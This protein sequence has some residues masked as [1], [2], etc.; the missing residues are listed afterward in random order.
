MLVKHSKS[1]EIA[2]GDEGWLHTQPISGWKILGT[3]QH[4]RQKEAFARSRKGV[5]ARVNSGKLSGLDQ[6]KVKGVLG[7]LGRL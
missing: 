4:G 1:Y 2:L 5:Y 7:S 3:I 6:N